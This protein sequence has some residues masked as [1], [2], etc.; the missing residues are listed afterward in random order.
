MIVTGSYSKAETL[1]EIHNPLIRLI[2]LSDGSTTLHLQSIVG[3]ENLELKV[4]D[5]T[6]RSVGNEGRIERK[7]II[8]YQGKAYTYNIV[9]IFPHKRIEGAMLREMIE[10]LIPL[11]LLLQKYEVKVHRKLLS[12]GTIDNGTVAAHFPEIPNYSQL[13]YKD[14]QMQ[15]EDGHI[16]C[17]VQEYFV[18]DTDSP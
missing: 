13:Y 1:S 4:V 11:G 16:L 18:F 9:S 8:C 10:G 6:E 14:Y 7:S 12:C 3:S 15:L 5:Q 17:H 2:L